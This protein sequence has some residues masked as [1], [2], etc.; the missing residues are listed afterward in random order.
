MLQ[1]SLL[2]YLKQIMKNAKPAK[3]PASRR[4]PVARKS[5]PLHRRISL[6]PVT[7]MLL[8][9]IGILML[10]ST[11]QALGASTSVSMSITALPLEDPATITSP[12][13]QSRFSVPDITVNGTCPSDSYVKLYKNDVFSGAAP[14]ETGKF[15]IILNLQKGANKLQVRVFNFSN[16]EGPQSGS[17]TVHYD[18]PTEVPPNSMRP[19]PPPKPTTDLLR[20]I[21][22]YEYRV[23]ASGQPVTLDIK[24][25]GG[26]APYAIAIDW[27]DG[28]F[29][30]IP[31]PDTSAF[32][33][34]HIYPEKPRLYTYVIKVA[35]SDLNG[36]ADYI[37]LMAAVDRKD[38][39]NQSAT[40][41]SESPPTE[42]ITKSRFHSL[43]KFLWPAY[44]IVVLMVLSFYL[45]EREERRIM[46][47]KNRTP[48]L[49]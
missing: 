40:A 14:C 15:E 36:N 9:C 10:Y 35:V 32:Q 2:L 46:L 5:R 45:G 25:A 38:K 42:T 7:I 44:I 20:I 48:L 8:L 11:Y 27:N 13:D 17:I 29:I 12:A 6:H 37:Q 4:K 23:L 26:I 16:I 1:Q 21:T 28:K 47:R 34:E 49:R 30:P 39:D 19:L 24:L 18:A 43:L 22:E 3:R 41:A 33:V 31:R